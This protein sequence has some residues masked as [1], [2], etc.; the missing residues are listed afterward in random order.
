MVVLW[1]LPTFAVTIAYFGGGKGKWVERSFTAAEQ[2]IP[3]WGPRTGDLYINPD[4]L[5]AN[6]PQRVWQYELGGYPVLKKWLG[7]RRTEDPNCRTLTLADARHFRSMIQRLSALLALHEQMDQL[8]EQA[9]ADAFSAEN[10]GLRGAIVE[11]V[12]NSMP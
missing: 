2:A 5:F 6:V 11:E 12:P 7:Y 1:R 4:V 10:L 3:A 9:A 8:Y